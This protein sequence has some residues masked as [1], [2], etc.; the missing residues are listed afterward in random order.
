MASITQTAHE[1]FVACE[2]GKGWA[3]CRPT[4][5]GTH[6]AGGPVAPTG[7]TAHADYVSVM[8]FEGDTI[9]HMT[10]VWHSGLT[11]KELGWA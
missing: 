3:A 1:F 8:P 11:L 2:A 4:F 5:I 9:S 10:K 7:K 6:R